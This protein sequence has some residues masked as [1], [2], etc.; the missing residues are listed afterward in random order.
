ML[1]PLKNF[2]RKCYLDSFRGLFQEL[3]QKYLHMFVSAILS[4]GLGNICNGYD[5]IIF[6]K[7][8]WFL[9]SQH[10]FKWYSWPMTQASKEV[11]SSWDQWLNTC[12]TNVYLMYVF[13][14]SLFFLW[15]KQISNFNDQSIMVTNQLYLFFFKRF[16]VI[17]LLIRQFQ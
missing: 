5:I 15:Q 3:I 16:L 6:L 14:S 13:T 12:T 8:L 10:H 7:M 9:C 2:S 1:W 17:F 11:Y 4:L